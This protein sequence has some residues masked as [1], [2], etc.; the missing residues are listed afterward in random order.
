MRFILLV[1]SAIIEDIKNKT[2]VKDEDIKNERNSQ[3]EDIK[4]ERNANLKASVAYFYFDYKDVSKRDIRGLLASILFQLSEISDGCWNVL[5]KLFTACRD[6][7]EQPSYSALVTC[8][9]SMIKL[10]EQIFI[11][12]DA[13]DEC[14]TTGIPSSRDEVLA[15]I[16]DLIRVKEPSTRKL[17]ICVTSR[18]ELDIQNVLGS[19]P[20]ASTSCV[21]LHEESGQRD[22]VENYLRLFV[23]HDKVMRGWTEE[24]RKLVINTLLERGG[25]M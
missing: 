18:P 16:K 25:G 6:G 17:S 5:Y 22:D 10:P 11:V 15:F 1:S 21:S 3:V 14:P 12:V 9:K 2:N 8:F 19:L 20:V 23:R 4:N 13:L 7:Y 24:D